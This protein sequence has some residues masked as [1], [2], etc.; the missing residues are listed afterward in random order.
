MA[1]KK[2]AIIVPDLDDYLEE[3]EEMVAAAIT[4]ILQEKYGQLLKL[5]DERAV[6]GDKGDKGD[7]GEVNEAKIISEILTKIP[8]PK[9]GDDGSP[10]TGE[11]IAN[12]LNL[13]KEVIE[14]K[15]IKGLEDEIKRLSEKRT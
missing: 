12:K 6:K 5:I 8:K 7:D 2:R 10:D 4:K 14:I 3:L 11:Q 13:L 15:V 1:K 9:D